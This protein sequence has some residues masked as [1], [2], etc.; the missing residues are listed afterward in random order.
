MYIY[1]HTKLPKL[2]D[3][4]R[5]RATRQESSRNRRP[6]LLRIC[7]G[8]MRVQ[9]WT[10]PRTYIYIYIPAPWS[11]WVIYI[12]HIGIT[13]SIENGPTCLR[14]T[15]YYFWAFALQSSQRRV[16]LGASAI[17]EAVHFA[18]PIGNM[19]APSGLFF[20]TNLSFDP[21]RGNSWYSSNLHQDNVS[22]LWEKD[23]ERRTVAIPHLMSPL[24]SHI[25]W[26]IWW[27]GIWTCA[28]PREDRVFTGS[29]EGR[30]LPHSHPTPPMHCCSIHVPMGKTSLCTGRLPAEWAT[31]YP[32]QICV[33]MCLPKQGSPISPMVHHS[34]IKPNFR[35]TQS[36][37]G[38]PTT[39]SALVFKIRLCAD[40]SAAPTK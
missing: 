17:Y 8:W 7:C 2:Q 32:H 4:S 3:L 20:G 36:W 40:G 14:Q 1:I 29:P 35:C 26:F 31:A 5:S 37:Q 25:W 18:A 28:S 10:I 24:Y 15:L 39:L 21:R 38:V 34:S 23:R 19:F 30:S 12:W 6:R 13:T 27:P 9:K 16:L 22:Q 33:S 11:I